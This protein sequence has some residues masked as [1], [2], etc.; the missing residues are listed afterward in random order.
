MF[1][2]CIAIHIYLIS[3]LILIFCPYLPSFL[4]DKGRNIRERERERVER[5]RHPI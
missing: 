2:S 4:Q 1:T 3:C 5:R